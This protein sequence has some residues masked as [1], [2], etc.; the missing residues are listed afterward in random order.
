MACEYFVN[1]QWISESKFKEVLNNG[2]LDNLV[3]DGTIELKGFN[4]KTENLLS[5][6]SNVVTRNTVPAKKL[7]E[8]L[9]QEVSTRQGYP[10]NMLSALELNKEGTDFKIPLWA[11][12]YSDKFESL[13]TSLVSNKIVKQKFPG[14]SYVLGSQEGFQIKEGDEANNELFNSGIAFSSNFD[15]V[16]GL[17]PMRYDPSTKK[18]LPAQ[19]MIP[20]KFRNEKGDILN[21]EEFTKQDE[22]GKTILDFEK[23]PEKVL[24]LFGFRIPTQERNSMSALEIVGFLPEASGDLMLAPRDFTKQMGSDFDV[25][26]LYTYMYNT[27]YKDGKL[28]TDFESNKDTI[29]KKQKTLNKQLQELKEE[30]TLS[31]E[32]DGIIDRY[33]KREDEEEENG[34]TAIFQSLGRRGTKEVVDQL[35]NTILELSILERSY[36]A[37]R[38]NSIID[39]HLQIMTSSNP[40][41][42]ASIMALDSFGEF[43]GLSKEIS[44]IRLDRGLIPQTTTILS[45][46]YQRTKYINATAGK[47]GVGTFSLDST[48]NATA[49]GKDLIYLELTDEAQEQLDSAK[50]ITTDKILSLNNVITTFGDIVS[51]GD[52]SNKY[53]LRS[54]EIIKKAK[55]RN[56][57]K[58]EKESLKLKSTIIRAL[59]SSAVDNEK[60]QILDKLNINNETFDTIRALAILGFEEQDIVGLLTQEIIWEYIDKLKSSQSSLTG[61]NPNAGKDIIE[62]LREKYDSSRRIQTLEEDELKRF[63]SSSGEQLLDNIKN[64]KLVE[65]KNDTSDFNVEQL[66]LLDKFL[67]LQ[68]IG[69][70]IKTLQSTINTE[71]KGIPKSLLE[72]DAKIKQIENLPNSIVY[73]ASKLLGEYVDNFLLTPTTINGYASYYGVK[74]T[75]EIFSPYF[76]Y[77]RNGFK[78]VS[79]DIIQH[80]S[81]TDLSSSKESEVKDNVF[82]NIRSFLFSNP[83][84]GLFTENADLERQR[85]F[86]DSPTN[87]SLATILSTVSLQPWYLKNGF[88][89]KISF[90][91]NKNGDVSRIMFEASTGENFDER[92]IYLGFLYL[93][94]K[95]FSI[96]TFNGQEYTTRT[97][98][99]DLIAAAFLEGGNQGSKQYSKYIPV[100]YLKSVNFGNY[101]HS[102]GFDFE[103]TFGGININGESHYL[104]P[105]N[106]T[107]QYFQN[108]PNEVKTVELKDK[109]SNPEEFE[110]DKDQLKD[111]FV[112]ITNPITGDQDITQTHFVSVFNSKLD[113]KYDLYEFDSTSRTYKKL[114]ALKGKYGFTQYNSLTNNVIPVSQ[115]NSKSRSLIE[116]EHPNFVPPQQ[117][118]DSNTIEN[119]NKISKLGDLD[120]KLNL[121]NREAL[122]DLLNNLELSDSVYSYNRKLI[123]EFRN[124][125]L[126]TNFKFE[127]V[128]NPKGAKASFAINTNTLQLNLSQLQDNSADDI[129]TVLLHELTH[130]FTS[131]AIHQYESGNISNLTNEQVQAIKKLENL[132]KQYVNHLVNN[133]QGDKLV[134]FFNAY[135]TWRFDQG[136]IS[137]EVLD[138]LLDRGPKG[139]D[140]NNQLL[141]EADFSKESQS[142]YYG[143]IKLSE[144]V[145]MALTDRGFQEQLN[146]IV[147][148]EGKSVWSALVDSLLQLLQSLGLTVNKNSLL[149]SALEESLNLVKS[150]K[151]T[152]LNLSPEDIQRM[153]NPD[154]LNLDYSL[155]ED[156]ASEYEKYLLI[157]GK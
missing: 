76:P 122:N 60:A 131:S 37:S 141:P 17:Q 113:S 95:N 134:A 67:K 102:V 28:H 157:C 107:R 138:S 47:D 44:K 40:E 65:S 68:E 119:T 38:Q 36:K 150:Q 148:S 88:L 55:G 71:S 1:G 108:N 66:L 124:I 56:L 73:N 46:T 6:K 146:N 99:Q 109:D 142:K 112:T 145:T 129:A 12:P 30:I 101:L 81:N 90:D 8:I 111:N 70:T 103:N 115:K 98:A 116:Q 114:P 41:I 42:I 61:Y 62:S 13:L 34:L 94:D 59:Q 16:K 155:P 149:A 92:N 35:K 25:D 19:I 49:Q 151:K 18:I 137:K 79:N 3:N 144:F 53:T 82:G 31:K 139:V 52:M 5:N 104:Y 63:S 143:A 20:F 69:K 126:P 2:L 86:I 152:K 91:E 24:T 140:N 110:L 74:T 9:T 106:F 100:S 45:E 97:L 135:H 89:N 50:D 14:H 33:I 57:T 136:R 21:V 29:K 64:K 26:K 133:N 156:F 105:S 58:E 127:Y 83:E 4:T 117:T 153:S 80:L 121:S 154:N 22:D 27:Y 96:G 72:V 51:K 54:Q 147:N 77:R 78:Q 23:I 32:E 75:D 120:I 85:I 11:S 43:E 84:I 128:K 48:F 130:S 7:A 125:S 132:Q 10:L 93:L 118:E 15:P 39:I 87:T 123:E